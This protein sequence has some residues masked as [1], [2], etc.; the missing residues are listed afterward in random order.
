MPRTLKKRVS[1]KKSQSKPV[2]GK[3]LSIIQSATTC[4]DRRR[5]T[6]FDRVKESD[7]A[8]LLEVKD[9]YLSGDYP[10]LNGEALSREIS[11]ELGFPVSG[12]MFRRWA[13]R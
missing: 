10:Q 9:A 6:W 7:K 3:S 4:V 5:I 8:W 2:T 1:A 12:L 13:N 11:K